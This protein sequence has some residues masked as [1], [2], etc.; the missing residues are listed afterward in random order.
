MRDELRCQMVL[1]RLTAHDRRLYE[2]DPVVHDVAH[3]LARSMCDYG[4]PIVAAAFRL[5]LGMAARQPPEP[6][7]THLTQEELRNRVEAEHRRVRRVF[8]MPAQEEG[9]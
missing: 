2:T 5:A 1:P 6:R 4:V 9:E 8:T 7:R 3:M